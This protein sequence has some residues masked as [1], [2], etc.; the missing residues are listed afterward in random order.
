MLIFK[1][2]IN[3][4]VYFLYSAIIIIYTGLLS[5]ISDVNWMGVHRDWCWQLTAIRDSIYTW[6]YIIVSSLSLSLSCF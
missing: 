2:L 4:V 3:S 1:A 6:T 5:T